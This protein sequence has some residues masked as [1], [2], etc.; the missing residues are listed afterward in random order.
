VMPGLGTLAGSLLGQGLSKA[1]GWFKGLFGGDDSKKAAEEAAKMAAQQ[2]AALEQAQ[3]YADSLQTRLSEAKGELTGLIGEAEKLGY[4]FNEQGELTSVSFERM[5]EVAKSYGIDLASLGPQ[6]QSARLHEGAAAIINDFELLTRGGA[7][8]GGVLFGMSGSISQLVTDSIKFGTA[9]PANMKPWIDELLRSGHLVD[10]NGVKITDLSA[11]QF[12]DPIATQ[13]E[14]ITTALQAVVDSLN[15]V[16]A[17]IAAIPTGRT[18]TI[19]TDYVDSGPPAGFGD[20]HVGERRGDENHGFA[21]GTKGVTGSWFADFG[22]STT[23]NLHGRQA[24]VRED[25][26]D[27]FVAAHGGSDSAALRTELR[28]LREDMSVA[29]RLQPTLIASAVAAALQA[30]V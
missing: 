15:R 19:R 16:A 30:R 26:T 12:G 7:D 24:V 27:A 18:V 25:Q 11:L 6:F 5:Q 29:A 17:S 21:G 28:G 13:F 3:Q 20:V 23:T 4:V 8:V 9:I 2:K 14:K 1:V 10:E 22:A